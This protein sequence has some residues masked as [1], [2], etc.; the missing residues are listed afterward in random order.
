VRVTYTETPLEFLIAS[1][2]VSVYDNKTE[3]LKYLVRNEGGL[4][5]DGEILKHHK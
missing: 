3:N 1:R 5:D 4:I 2:G